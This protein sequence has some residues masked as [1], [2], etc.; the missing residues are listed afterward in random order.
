MIKVAIEGPDGVGKTTVANIVEDLVHTAGYLVNRYHQPGATLCERLLFAADNAALMSHLEAGGACSALALFDRA[1]V[2][3]N[4]AY[5]MPLAHDKKWAEHFLNDLSHNSKQCVFD[6]LFILTAE[7]NTCLERR[8]KR[9]GS[10]RIEDR[11]TEYH[12]RVHE[13]YMNLPPCVT[14][15]C[16]S[17]DYMRTEG[18]SPEQVAQ[19][20]F[21]N[22]LPLLKG[23]DGT[24]AE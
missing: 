19:D 20:I 15:Y 22:I 12:R 5:F 13:C 4:Y 23:P 9:G 21:I 1:T 17:Y 24:P 16:R 3:S 11:G 18:L 10:D 8:S 7:F 2:V 14:S 6:K